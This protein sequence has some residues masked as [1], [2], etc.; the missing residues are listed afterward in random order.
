M[1]HFIKME[2]CGNDYIFVDVG[3]AADSVDIDSLGVVAD[4][5]P[6]IADRH[7]GVGGDGLILLSSGNKAPVR[8]RMWNADGSEGLLCLNGLRCVAKYAA[9]ETDAGD[10]F[11]VETAAGNRVV[12]VSRDPSGRVR[13]VEVEA[14]IPD[15]RR[16]SLPALGTGEELW[17][18][19]F[20]VGGMDL[21]GYAVSVGNPHLML[22]MDEEPALWRAPLE[23]IGEPFGDDPRFP[24]GINVHLL[25]KR[26]RGDLVMRSWE[27]G[28]GAT[29]ACGSGAAGAFAV[30][31]RLGTVAS[32][33][34][35][36]MPGGAVR[37]LSGD[38]GTLLMR[39]PARE[40][41]RGDWHLPEEG[42]IEDLR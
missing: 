37:M 21:L 17:H 24:E 30:A 1:V 6:R 40:V 38:D 13:E 31:R 41:F 12:R 19:P 18:E 22:W 34:T 27:R 35:V 20:Y 29:L 36:I 11:V 7:D 15:F 23:E 33:A 2:G 4:W 28:S 14:G 26:G 32:E 25:S 5:V 39:G 10:E 8:M 3:L 16:E 9:E 42:M